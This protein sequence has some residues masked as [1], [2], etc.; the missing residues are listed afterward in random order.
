MH[1]LN[2]AE[3]KVSLHATIE[4]MMGTL[5]LCLQLVLIE[6]SVLLIVQSLSKRQA[7]VYTRK[8]CQTHHGR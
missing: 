7:I 2:R 8:Q 1:C 6:V 5:Y 4:S 3:K